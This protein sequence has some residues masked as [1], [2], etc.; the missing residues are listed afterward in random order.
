MPSSSV[1]KS[2][3]LKIL[4]IAVER[5]KDERFRSHLQQIDVTLL[6]VDALYLRMGA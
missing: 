1:L 2:G 4:M 6:V 3:R 5:F